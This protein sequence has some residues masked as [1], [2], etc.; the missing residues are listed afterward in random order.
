LRYQTAYLGSRFYGGRFPPEWLELTDAEGITLRQAAIDWGSNP[1]EFLG[2]QA[3]ADLLGYLELHIEQGPVLEQENLSVGVVTAI[4]GQSRVA[5]EL[6][7]APGHAGTT[8]MTLR[9]DALA[10]AAAFVVEVERIA[11]SHPEAPGLVATVG[12]L[13]VEPGASNVIPG[14]AILTLDL[15][16]PQNAVREAVLAELET[17]FKKI[18]A[19]RGLEAVWTVRQENP[20]VPCD[21]DFVRALVDAASATQAVVPELVSGAGHDA[22]ALAPLCPVGMLFVTCRGGLSHHPDEFTAPEHIDVAVEVLTGAVRGLA[23]A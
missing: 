7:G 16:H 18:A 20:A 4:A 21:A 8:P 14:R 17:T 9:R 19:D 23:R 5:L 12:Q 10:G 3:R 15:R 2:Q 1:K 22:V 11:H 13:A 6:T